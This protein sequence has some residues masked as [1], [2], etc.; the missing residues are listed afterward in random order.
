MCEAFKALDIHITSLN[1]HNSLGVVM[2]ISLIIFVLQIKKPRLREVKVTQGV[3]G[4]GL[5]P[6]SWSFGLLALTYFKNTVSI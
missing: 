1:L 2:R 5:G 6:E 4:E 3:S